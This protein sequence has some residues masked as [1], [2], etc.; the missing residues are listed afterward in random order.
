MGEDRNLFIV[1]RMQRINKVK[2][3]QKREATAVRQWVEC[4]HLHRRRDMTRIHRV[5]E[6]P[7]GGPTHESYARAPAV[8]VA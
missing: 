4:A 7:A 3:R 8:M 6:A 1:S 5:V 2:D